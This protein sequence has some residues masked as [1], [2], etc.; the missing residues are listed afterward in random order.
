[1]TE[2]N[3][4]H[5]M[6]SFFASSFLIGMTLLA[7]PSEAKTTHHAAAHHHASHHAKSSHG[8][9]ASKHASG[10]QDDGSEIGKAS[11]YGGK[12]Q[13]KRTA[14]GNVFD[15]K[16]MVAA[17]RSLPLNSKARITNLANGKSVE[18]TVVDRG[19]VSHDRVIDVSEQAARLLDMKR[20]GIARVRVEPI[21]RVKPRETQTAQAPADKP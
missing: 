16:Q 2:L 10:L 8:K 17:H 4:E 3:I 15:C 12:L 7:T 13:G 21:A 18:V 14:D 6:K 1:M 11:W 9:A 20:A 5:G 19:P